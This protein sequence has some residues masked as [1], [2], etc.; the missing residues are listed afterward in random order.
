M[1]NERL[2]NR[3]AVKGLT[4]EDLASAIEVDPKTIERWLR[5]G[6]VPRQPHR[7]DAAVVLGSKESYLWPALLDDAQ[8]QRAAQA[9]ILQVFSQRSA[10]P[11]D[12]RRRLADDSTEQV[13][14]LVYA[15]LFMLD[16]NPELP[17]QIASRA[18]QGLKARF[19]YGDP[20]S[21]TVA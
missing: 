13:D 4:T 7:R 10:V 9:E 17:T 8:H 19:L 21:Q 3:M 14:V 16:T 12:L 6:R 2:R 11:A 5:N 15:G 20:D 18:R 1:G